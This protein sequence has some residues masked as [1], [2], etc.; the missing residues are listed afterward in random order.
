[1]VACDPAPDHAAR[2]IIR[3]RARSPATPEQSIAEYSN[4]SQP[5]ATNRKEQRERER[6]S[7][8]DGPPR[9]ALRHPSDRADQLRAVRERR[10]AHAAE[11]RRLRYSVGDAD[12]DASPGAERRRSRAL[13]SQSQPRTF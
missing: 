6:E 2:Y 13:S 10:E 3:A 9:L 1:V 4:L 8:S 12:G 7:T 5:F 11:P